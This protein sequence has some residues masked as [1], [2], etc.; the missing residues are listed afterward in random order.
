MLKNNKKKG[1]SLVILVLTIIILLILTSAVIISI[2]DNVENAKLSGFVNEVTQIQEALDSYYIINNSLPISGEELSLDEVKS[3]IDSKYITDFEEELSLNLDTT[4]KFYRIDF[5][6]IQIQNSSDVDMSKKDFVVSYPNLNVYSLNVTEINGVGYFSIT[7][8]V[9]DIIEYNQDNSISNSTTSVT[10]GVYLDVSSNTGIETNK[11]GIEVNISNYI[12]ET[13]TVYLEITGFGDNLK[14][15]NN[16]SNSFSFNTLEE[17][18]DNNIIEN[19]T[20]YTTISADAFN[21]ATTKYI[22]IVVKRNNIEI[23]RENLDMSNYKKYSFVMPSAQIREYDGMNVIR[24]GSI[25]NSSDLKEIRYDYL[26]KVDKNNNIVYYY[27]GITSFDE[28]HMREKSKVVSANSITNGYIDIKIPSNIVTVCF[29][30]INK[31]GTI[32]EIQTIAVK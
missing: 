4:A 13:D 6:L 19:S 27:D 12:K 32:S 25:N 31:Y 28:S 9:N 30:Y 5:S 8:K 24:I 23:A 29:V 1:I 7:S 17:L 18:I 2:G 26:E 22:N 15:N 16:I 21:T 20:S 14:V 10:N 11:L 3:L